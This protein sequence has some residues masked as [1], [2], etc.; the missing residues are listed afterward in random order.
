MPTFAALMTLS[1]FKP[2]LMAVVFGGW[3]W[4]ASTLDKDL[5]YFYLKRFMW[6]GIQMAAGIAAFGLW[7]VVPFFWLGLA[8]AHPPPLNAP[9]SERDT[10]SA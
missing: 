9:A 4:I 5:A 10:Q 3:A 6:N 2:L 7:L 1:I 8:A